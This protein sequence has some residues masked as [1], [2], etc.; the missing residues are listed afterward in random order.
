MTGLAG[1]DLDDA[2][3][4]P[5]ARTRGPD[6]PRR[7]SASSPASRV[8]FTLVSVF[9]AS[10][11]RTLLGHAADRRDGR[12]RGHRGARPGLPRADPG[13]AAGVAAAAS[14]PR[15]AWPAPRC[16]ARVFALSWTARAWAPPSA[17]SSPWPS[18]TVRPPA[19]SPWPSRTASGL[20]L[21]FLAF[22]LG[23]RK[24]LGVSP[25]DPPAQRLGHPDRWRLLSWSGWPSR[26]GCG[27]TSSSGYRT[28]RRPAASGEA[29][30][31]GPC[32]ASW[33]WLTSMRT[34][35]IL[36]LLLAIAAIP[37]SLLPQTEPRPGA[38][39]RS[40]ITRPPDTR[41]AAGPARL[42]RRVLLALVLGDLPAAVRLAGRLP[43]APAA[44][45]PGQPAGQAAGGAGRLDRL[46]HV[47]DRRSRRATLRRSRPSGS[48]RA[49]RKQRWRVAVREQADGVGHRHRREGLHQGERQPAVP[50][51]PAGA[52]D[53]GR[54]RFVV[55]LERQPVARGRATTRASA[56]PSS[57]TTRYRWAPG[58]PGPTC[59][60]SA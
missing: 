27:T 36:L 19:R 6:H 54:A 7:A 45:A 48:R 9:A 46:P 29:S 33:R 24:L 42:L 50:L 32:G 10:V 20:G 16:S 3:N 21:P 22:G 5:T 17:R 39:R 31:G 47:G 44:P 26:P 14:C 56:T 53:R 60:R 51:R 34:A 58:R 12:R 30:D 15:P 41:P 11:G 2:L 43:G 18:P 23:F 35:L 55:R 59:R 13:A 49:L 4:R 38:G 52:A 37:G 8:V 28:S 57:S 1:A 25:G 40:Y